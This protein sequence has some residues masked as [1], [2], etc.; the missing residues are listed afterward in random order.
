LFHFLEAGAA[1][2]KAGE[3]QLSAKD[4][5]KHEGASNY[6]EAANCYKKTNPQMAADCLQKAAEIYTD[7]VSLADTYI[8]LR[9]H[10]KNIGNKAQRMQK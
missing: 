9:K 7:M 4:P 2:V 1:F 10:P 5:V 3:L 8:K 6:A